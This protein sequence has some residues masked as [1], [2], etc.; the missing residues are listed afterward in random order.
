MKCQYCQKEFKRECGLAMHERTCKDNP[1]RKPLENHICNFPAKQ[2]KE[3]GWSCCYCDSRFKTR[4]D[5][6]LHRDKVHPDRKNVHW[7]KGLTK[8]TNESIKRQS[9]TY[10]SNI[11]NGK[12][13]PSKLGKS[14]SDSTKSKISSSMKIAHAEGRAHNIGECRWNNKPSYPEQWFMNMMENEFNQKVD[15][16]YQREFSFHKFSI[17][18]AWPDKKICVEIDGEQHQKFQEQIVRDFE[19]DSLLKDEGW[20]EIRRSWKYIF[21]NTKQFIEEIKYALGA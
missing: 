3:G 9:E 18:F 11:I 16:D 15:I 12:I 21:N 7:N 14:V 4:K 13:I 8:E 19:K 20:I 10:H 6:Y 2:S 17:D 1:N 5:L